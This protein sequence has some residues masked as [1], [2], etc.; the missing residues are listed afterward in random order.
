MN[1]AGTRRRK[2]SA[3]AAGPFVVALALAVLTI[4][5]GPARAAVSLPLGFVD[6]L[7]ASVSTPTAFAF[8]PDG[9]MLVTQQ[10]GTVRVV[11]DGALL[12][13]A[14]LDLTSK[15]CSNS[16]RGLLGVA[17]D[18]AFAS[19]HYVY[20]YYTYKKFGSCPTKQANDPVNRVSR[21]VL[22]ASNVINPLTETV[23]IDNM[24]TWAGNHNAG[25]VGFGKDGYLYASV[26]D[27]GCDYAGDSSCGGSNDA[28]RDQNVLLGKILR[29]TRDGGIP[30]DNPFQ[31]VLSARCASTGSTVKGGQCKETYAWGLRNPF[32]FAFDPNAAGTKL[33]INDVGQNTWEEVDLGQAG[34]DYGWNVREGHC[35]TGSTTNCGPPPAGMTNPVFDYSHANG[36]TS[37]TGG[38]FVPAGIGWPASY[39]GKYLFGDYVCGKIFRMDPSGPGFVATPFATGLGVGSVVHMG[40]GPSGATQ[41]LYYSSYAGGGQIRRISFASDGTPVA[42][43]TASPTN[44]VAPLNVSFDGSQ[45]QD[46]NEDPLTYLW[47]FG[48]GATASTSGPSTV[49]SYTTN[50][51]FTASLRVK[52]PGGLTSSP[53]TVT[54]TVGNA[55]PVPVITS[56]AAGS[57]FSVGQT[58]TLTGSATDPEDGTLPPSALSWT[59]LRFHKDHTHPWFGP[60]GGNNL[61]FPAPEPED[62]QAATN[63]YLIVTLTATDSTGFSTSVTENV[64]P[65]TV[66]LTFTTNPTGLKVQVAG[67]NLVAPSAI[68]SWVGWQININAPSPQGTYV[69]LSWSDGGA[70]SH[71][72]T[73]P[74]TPTTYQAKFVHV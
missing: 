68:T 32:R 44:G 50:G 43:L 71:T 25:N 27:G 31:G 7:V 6:Q 41:A 1:G 57:T 56:P 54:V 38:A 73:S 67:V 28:S 9:R 62:L 26:G 52:D 60:A 21:F 3:R 30:P 23:L 2:A 49:H 16:E 5:A 48:D 33:H 19:N 63:S 59:V 45:S 34:A 35:A 18:P 47:D 17:V 53:A 70:R 37:I 12:G 10:P 14:A 42:A 20:L 22:P 64:M 29:I 74:A 55:P 4:P 61:T 15:T 24:M 40:F 36:C 66:K 58:L 8:T 13:T 65:R 39:G 46:P 51:T 11:K 69:F 72:I